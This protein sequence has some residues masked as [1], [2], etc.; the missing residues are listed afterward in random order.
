LPKGE[1]LV[2]PSGR[3]DPY[4][5]WDAYLQSELGRWLPGEFFARGLRAQLR[6]NNLLGTD[7]PRYANTSSGVQPY[8]DWRG[9][10]YSISL[11]A[12][13]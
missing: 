1:W 7:F 10:T 8:G 12:A 4:W 11:T 5:Q 2:Q 6:V 3:V 9:R 13:F